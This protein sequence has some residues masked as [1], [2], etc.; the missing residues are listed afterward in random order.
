[1]S[2][3][4]TTAGPETNAWARY[5][6]TTE[7]PWDLRRVVH[8]HRRAG[9]AASWAEI[10]RDLREGPEQSINRVL[11]GSSRAGVAVDDFEST[12]SLIA[13]AA[14]ASGDINRL[15]AW[16]IFRMLASPDPLAERL[17]LMW[18]DHFATAVSKVE[19]L[20]LMRR[21]NETFRRLARAPFGD[22]LN[23]SV[24]EPAL[25]LYLDAPSNRKDHPNENLARELMELFTLGIGN[26]TEADVKEAARAL[27][28][29][30]VDDGAFREVRSKHD[31]GEKT[32]LGR[33]GRWLPSGLL[34]ILLESPATARRI[35]RR[36]CGLLMG[37]EVVDESAS[38]A[39]ADELQ[40][41]RLDVGHAVEKVIRSRAFFAAE[42]IRSRV[43]GP[44]EFVIGACR[45]LVPE[46]AIPS[47]L[48]LADWTGRLGQELFEPPNVG[49][50]PGGRAW[51]FPRSLVGRVNFA[52]ALVD[53]RPVG[54]PGPLDAG[55]IAAVQGL[56]KS[57]AAVRAA[58]SALLFGIAA[59][60]S[61]RAAN[62]E[63]PKAA[64]E[65]LVTVLG[66]PEAQ[67]G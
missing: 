54:L 34:A 18:H 56:G 58:A 55:S 67:I 64:R 22:L 12:A 20:A 11:T 24:R 53:G 1:V 39:L 8:L 30:T 51:L 35:A 60:E 16:W 9:F 50:W 38:L 65:A 29:W 63:T 21:Q 3:R 43:V 23:A 44:V 59:R 33:K 45:A 52:A 57:A 41:H 27:T 7:A 19:D 2:P 47:T 36:I 46:P 14:V 25:L 66:S 17:T 40:T 42:N 26:F 37:E 32:V 62:G 31:D 48:L 15:R 13:D 61:E 6:P 5:E 10:K 49:G 4:Q 28:G